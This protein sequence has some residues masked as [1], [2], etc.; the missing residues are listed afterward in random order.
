ML[1]LLTYADISSV[2]PDAMTAWKAENLWRLYV[3]TTNYLDR[4]VDDE[5]VRADV[6]DEQLANIR[7]IAPQL[8]AGRLREYL[9]GLPRRYLRLHSAQDIVTHVELAAKLHAEPVQT[10]LTRFRD[11]FEMTVVTNDQPALFAKLAGILAA[12]GMNIVKADAFSNA[13]G[14][15]VD[16]FFFTDRF[17]TL[18]L[19]VQEWDRFR[20]SFVGV[21]TGGRSLEDLGSGRK[22]SDK[23]MPKV[24]IEPR[25]QVDET[26][27]AHSTVVEVIAQDRPGLLYRNASVLAEHGC[28]IEV[29]LI[30]TEGE[31]A[32]DVFYLT[33]RRK[34]L[35]AEAVD[36]IRD[37]LIEELQPPA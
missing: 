32:I 16:T 37:S 5:R 26:S 12:W 36:K 2:N 19:N 35:P 31:M 34:K 7:L 28:N 13:A 24:R 23:R 1:C 21:L 27:A 29:A 20:R 10:T 9:E 15:V 17:H 6:R 18:E 4:S 25:V 33:S 14:V 3:A 30:D 11:T 8:E 22:H